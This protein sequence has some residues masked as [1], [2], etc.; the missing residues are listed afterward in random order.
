ME[1]QSIG[2]MKKI[3]FSQKLIKKEKLSLKEK[4]LVIKVCQKNI[5]TKIKGRN[6][7]SETSLIKMYVT[8][9][10]GARRLVMV[11]DEGLDVGYFLMYRKK[12]DT[13]GEN[14]TLKNP[15]FE[16]ALLQYL[17]ILDVDMNNNNFEVIEL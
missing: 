3:I 5:F 11:L 14:V 8:T 6:L 16:K 2:C 7:P 12:D 17:E 1:R 9:I 15:A 13:I 10:E 4:Q